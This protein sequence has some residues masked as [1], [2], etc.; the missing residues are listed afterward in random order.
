MERK[1]RSEDNF[2]QDTPIKI[3]ELCEC[4]SCCIFLQQRMYSDASNRHVVDRLQDHHDDH[5]SMTV[6]LSTLLVGVSEPDCQKGLKDDRDSDR[7]FTLV[8]MRISTQTS[9]TFKLNL[10]HSALPICDIGNKNKTHCSTIMS[11]DIFPI[12]PSPV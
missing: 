5:P 3:A 6:P 7:L 4:Y 8:A 12:P 9:S 2:S 1:E 10:A 11:V